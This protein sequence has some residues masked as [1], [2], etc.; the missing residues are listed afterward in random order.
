MTAQAPNSPDLPDPSGQH[1]SI[2]R[3]LNI[4]DALSY[5]DA[6]KATFGEHQ[7]QIFNQFLDIMKEYQTDVTDTPSTVERVATLFA[8]HPALIQD[9][10]TFLPDGYRIDCSG[11][12]SITVITPTGTTTMPAPPP[13]SAGQALTDTRGPA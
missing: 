13:L 2:Q 7:P 6:I 3:S 9:F 8:G 4:M 1:P 5:L 11:E 12:S 10:N